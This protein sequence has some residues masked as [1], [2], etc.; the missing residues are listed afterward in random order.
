V[1]RAAGRWF[2][3]RKSTAGTDT[4]S[5]VAASWLPLFRPV[6]WSVP[7]VRWRDGWRAHGSVHV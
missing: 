7:S 6:R 2:E 3:Q 5:M 1:L 4:E